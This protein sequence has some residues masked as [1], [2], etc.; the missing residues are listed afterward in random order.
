M[1]NKTRIIVMGCGGSGG[2]PYAGNVWGACDPTNPK[3]YRTR[4][5]ILIEQGDTRVVVDTGPE[6]RIQMNRT[7]LR[8]DQL[9]HGVLYTHTHVDH[10]NGMDDLR[11]YW[12]RSGKV[13]V[14]V[15]GSEKTIKNL[16][17]QFQYIL[18]QEHPEYPVTAV[19]HVLPACEL[20]I[21]GMKIQHFEQIHGD[22]TTTGYRVGDFAYSTDVNILPDAALDI[23]KGVKTWVVGTHHDEIG[24]FNHAGFNQI[25]EWVN[26]IKPEMTYLTHLNAGADYQ[27]LCDI[28]PPNIR[29][30]YDGLE[31]FV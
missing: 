30:A 27:K 20:D 13:P 29:P 18:V 23:L 6:F 25:K 22:I 21:N 10:T 24:S 17:K 28:L 31:L 19:P 9:I 7:G 26:I 14:P 15:Y 11:T 4:P 5:S 1:Q 12:H 3:N 16:L 2:V 8:S